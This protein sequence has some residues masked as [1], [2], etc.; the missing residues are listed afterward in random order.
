MV[1]TETAMA[2]GMVTGAAMA[3]ATVTVTAASRYL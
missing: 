2:V 3:V 1:V